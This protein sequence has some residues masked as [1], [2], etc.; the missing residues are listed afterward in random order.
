[1]KELER[2]DIHNMFMK[3][4]DDAI[5]PITIFG[6]KLRPSICLLS[7]PGAFVKQK[8]VWLEEQFKLG[9]LIAKDGK[10]FEKVENEID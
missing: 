5:G 1:M 3:Y 10:V 8:H 6:T 2:L 4:V 9:N 7:Q